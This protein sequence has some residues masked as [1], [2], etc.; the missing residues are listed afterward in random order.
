VTKFVDGPGL[1]PDDVAEAI[2]P[3]GFHEIVLRQRAPGFDSGFAV[4][5]NITVGSQRTALRN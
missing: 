1:L 5:K 2:E 4:G 3:G